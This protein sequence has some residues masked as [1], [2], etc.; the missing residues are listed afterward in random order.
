M[1]N[2][3]RK[4]QDIEKDLVQGLEDLAQI[5]KHTNPK[6]QLYQKNWQSYFDFN[7]YRKNENGKYEIVLIDPEM[8]HMGNLYTKIFDLSQDNSSTGFN[9]Q[10]WS[11]KIK[12]IHASDTIKSK[13]L[14]ANFKK[15]LKE[16][17][18]YWE[19]MNDP[20]REQKE[21]DE[22]AEIEAC[23]TDEEGRVLTRGDWQEALDVAE[24]PRSY[25]EHRAVYVDIHGG[26]LAINASA[27]IE[28]FPVFE[29]YKQQTIKS[30]PRKRGDELYKACEL[31]KMFSGHRVL[32]ATKEQ[33]RAW[34]IKKY[35]SEEK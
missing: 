27:A 25:G 7:E 12:P 15:T 5:C 18:E 19:Y 17:Q 23:E 32:Y 9:V 2:Y 11:L 6:A 35:D 14:P 31:H 3:S 26:R 34:I 21:A 13:S 24:E 29:D 28:F 22:L 1:P 33:I 20:N 10:I 4:L 16:Y 30:D 8:S